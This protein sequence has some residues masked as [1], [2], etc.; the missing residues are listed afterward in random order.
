MHLTRPITLL[1]A[2]SSSIAAYQ[3]LREY[4][5][6]TFFD[7]W[8]YWGK[9]DDTTWGNVTYLDRNSA[10]T[11]RLTYVDG[12]GHAIVRVDNTT[13]I[14]PATLVNRPSI[15]ITSQDTYGVGNLIIIDVAH[16]PSGC[17]VWPSFW[18]LGAGKEWPHAGEID[19]IEGINLSNNNQMA[20]HADAGCAQAAN[21]GQSGKTLEGDCSLDRGCIVAETK[22]NSFGAGFNNAGG[23]VFATQIDISGVYIWFWSRPDIPPSIKEATSTS[24]MDTTTWGMPSASYPATGCNFTAFFGPQQLVLLT[25]LCGNW[26]GVP[27][28]YSSTC[29][30][31]CI[32][33][34]II[35]TGSPVYDNAYWDIAYIRTYLAEGSLPATPSSSSSPPVLPVTTT[36]AVK[37][38][39]AGSSTTTPAT[40]GGQGNGALRLD[41]A[42]ALW[43]M[44]SAGLLRVL[45]GLI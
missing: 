35:G 18:T 15:R 34:N 3:S 20:L 26:A 14:A 9:I 40:T 29:P 8:D 2:A 44:L 24:N 25:T 19:I 16:L 17:S 1:A 32:T 22:P 23:G 38:S 43:S 28:I 12:N 10:N 30:G 11:Q 39:A 21:P 13:N 6:N 4:A 27:S 45:S 7:K 36:S 37:T 41:G 42:I 31:N 5:G 33:S